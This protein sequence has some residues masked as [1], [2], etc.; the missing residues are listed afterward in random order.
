MFSTPEQE[1]QPEQEPKKEV[2]S[3]AAS[4][5]PKIGAAGLLVGAAIF[6]A[7]AFEGEKKP[8]PSKLVEAPKPQAPVKAPEPAPKAA[9]VAA[10]PAEAAKPEPAKAP[11]AQPGTK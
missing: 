5:G 6:L 11:V 3:G 8:Q 4:L 7:S 10:K 2:P 1:P 9:P